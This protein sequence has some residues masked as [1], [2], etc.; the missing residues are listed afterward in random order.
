MESTMRVSVPKQAPPRGAFLRRVRTKK[1][2]LR[3]FGLDLGAIDLASIM[4][5]VLVIGII[6]GVISATVFAVV[7]W[8]QDNAAKSNLD[9][10]HTAESVAQIKTGKFLSSIPDLVGAGFLP[11]A[12]TT[13]ASAAGTSLVSEI[14]GGRGA[15]VAG[16]AVITGDL[17]PSNGSTPPPGSY[18]PPPVPSTAAAAVATNYDGSCFIATTHSGSGQVFWT[19]NDSTVVHQLG[20]NDV[21]PSTNCDTPFPAIANIQQ[22]VASG[23]S[24]PP[25]PC[26]GSPQTTVSGGGTFLA[27]TYAAPVIL[28]A[29]IYQLSTSTICTGQSLDGTVTGMTVAVS[30]PVTLVGTSAPTLVDTRTPVQDQD[31]NIVPFADSAA[32]WQLT[33]TVTAGSNRVFTYT[34]TQPIAISATGYLRSAFVFGFRIEFD[35]TATVGTTGQVTYTVAAASPLVG[36]QTTTFNTSVSPSP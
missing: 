9:S 25:N 10:I 30:V 6:A 1:V 22:P 11:L 5:G 28:T 34:D 27:S 36:M 12:A 35:T 32:D 23:G 4:V 18:A 26:D 3:A 21:A 8:S 20:P 15:S 33:S 29:P 2:Q 31:A 17:N 24:V 14:R 19:T 13:T 16:G 7:P